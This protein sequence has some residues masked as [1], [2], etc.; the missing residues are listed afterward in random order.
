[1]TPR[2]KIVR[3]PSGWVRR[4]GISHNNE[5]RARLK[6]DD[7]LFAQESRHSDEVSFAMY[8]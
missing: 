8:V 6:V 7:G 1:M 5:V 3:K 2:V 4:D